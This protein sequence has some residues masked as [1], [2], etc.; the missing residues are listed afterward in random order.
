[1][2]VDEITVIAIKK[3]NKPYL[4]P[5]DCMC[6]LHCVGMWVCMQSIVLV[7]VSYTGALGSPFI[8]RYTI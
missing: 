3:K 4:L 7:G 5:S 1:M 8:S 6:Y 2:G